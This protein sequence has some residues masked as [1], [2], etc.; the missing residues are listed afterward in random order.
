MI[1]YALPAL[2]GEHDDGGIIILGHLVSILTSSV[3]G[4]HIQQ[5]TISPM[6]N[7]KV[8]SR[9]MK[10]AAR[11][12]VPKGPPLVAGSMDQQ[13]QLICQVTRLTQICRF[14]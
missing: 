9:L 7:Q 3:V 12:M 13:Q 2:R 14:T 4:Q 10:Q 11:S 6:A 5:G 1:Q 8:V